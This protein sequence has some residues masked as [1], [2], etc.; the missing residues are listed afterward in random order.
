MDDG[1]YF[2]CRLE[3]VSSQE[4]ISKAKK[5][6]HQKQHSKTGCQPNHFSFQSDLPG[7]Q[8]KGRQGDQIESLYIQRVLMGKSQRIAKNAK[9]VKQNNIHEHNIKPLNPY[10]GVKQ[11][12]GDC[13]H[14]Y[15]EQ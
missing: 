8:H 4:Y 12:G 9:K 10:P 11:H 5:K 6:V 7:G 3:L 13:N 1:R 2:E 15:N 14:P